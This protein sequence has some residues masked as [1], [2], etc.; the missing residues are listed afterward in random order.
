[1]RKLN[2]KDNLKRIAALIFIVF[3]VVFWAT[4]EQAGGSLSIYAK[5]HLDGKLLLLSPNQ[6]NNSANSMFVILFA[7]LLGLFWVWLSK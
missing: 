1:M 5:E 7:P 3:S 4:F 2:L 6:I